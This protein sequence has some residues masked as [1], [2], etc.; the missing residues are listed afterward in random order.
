M[1]G[2]FSQGATNVMVSVHDGHQVVVVGE[3]PQVT[4]TQISNGVTFRK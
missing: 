1:V 4:V 2:S 3:V